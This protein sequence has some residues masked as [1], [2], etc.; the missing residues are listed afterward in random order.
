MAAEITD[1]LR[2]LDPA[3]PVRC[4]F[5]LCHLGMMGGCGWGTGAATHSARYDGVPA[6]DGLVERVERH[7]RRA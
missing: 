1:G 7:R 6:D 4:D 2:R 3:D 5:A